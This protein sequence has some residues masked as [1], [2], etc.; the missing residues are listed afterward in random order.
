MLECNI[1]SIFYIEYIF[2]LSITEYT[3]LDLYFKN[4]EIGLGMVIY[5]FNSSM[6]ETEAG[7]SLQV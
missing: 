6:W 5:T 2:I 7:K 3:F 1:L 4:I